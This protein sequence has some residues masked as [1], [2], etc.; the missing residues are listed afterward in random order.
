MSFLKKF[1]GIKRSLNNNI[2]VSNRSNGQK[3][4]SGHNI[5]S[6]S[7]L[8]NLVKPLLRQTTKLEI[9]PPSIPSD[10]VQFES[11][12]GGQPYFEKGQKWPSS[13]DGKYLDFIF[14]IVNSPGLELPNNIGLVQFFYD[15]D[16]FPW[17][18][19]NDGWLV[20]IYEKVDENKYE[21]IARPDSL[22]ESKYCSVVYKSTQTLPDWEGIDLFESDASSLSSELNEGE[23]WDYY[24]RIV[25]KLVGEQDY[26]SQLGGYPKWVQGEATPKTNKGNPMKLLFQIDSDDNAELMWGD[27]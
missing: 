4:K 10:R 16:E 20:K 23:P 22:K 15:W 12:F 1:F 18:T 24:D 2:P 13:R 9:Q 27:V 26:Q 8:E 5:K 11:H 25:N 19:E 6:I 14:Q 7:D 17:D 3:E 21:F